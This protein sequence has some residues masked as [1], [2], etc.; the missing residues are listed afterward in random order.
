MKK[1]PFNLSLF[2]IIGLFIG[3]A[4]AVY[5][6]TCP[7]ESLTTAGHIA[8]SIFWLAAWLYVSEPIPVY[9]TSLLVILLASG[10]LAKEGPLYKQAKP[11]LIEISADSNGIYA[12]PQASIFN[13][14]F[15]YQYEKA[16]WK[17][18]PIEIFENTESQFLVKLNT[19]EPLQI[20]ADAYDLSS[21]YSPLSYKS[22]FGTLAD[23]IIVLFL[24]GF[25]LARGVLHLPLPKQN[26]EVK[27]CKLASLILNVSGEN[28]NTFMILSGYY[29]FKI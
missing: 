6:I 13:Q 5:I 14:T 24:G 8:L 7:F 12:V 4:G 17:K 23:P 28:R 20:S 29:L 1:N 22:I 21:G 19:K 2:A 25:M 9:A 16:A 10:L 11:I 18:L 15:V 26:L 27:C 3:L